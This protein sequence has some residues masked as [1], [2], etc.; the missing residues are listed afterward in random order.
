MKVVIKLDIFYSMSVEEDVDEICLAKSQTK[1]AI[2]NHIFLGFPIAWAS[3]PGLPYLLLLS[4]LIK[5]T[6][7][8]SQQCFTI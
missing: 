8:M 3:Y 2:I 5:V 4:L 1:V 6:V 7:N